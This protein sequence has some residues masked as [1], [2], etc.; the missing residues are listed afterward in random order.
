MQ[1]VKINAV[2][3]RVYSGPVYNLE[4]VSQS[5]ESDDLFWIEQSTGIVTHNCFPKDI[6]ALISVMESKGI[7]PLLLKASWEQNKRIRDRWDW[8]ESKSA[9]SNPKPQ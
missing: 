2:R 7:D 3:K 4:I 1:K 9:V 6:N 5:K 8:A